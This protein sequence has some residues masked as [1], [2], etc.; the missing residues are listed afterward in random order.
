MNDRICDSCRKR[1]IDH[2]LPLDGRTRVIPIPAPNPFLSLLNAAALPSL[3]P[4]PQPMEL[5]F[6]PL[7]LLP[8]PPSSPPRAPVSSPRFD[9]ILDLFASPLLRLPL[10][11]PPSPEVAE[12]GEKLPLS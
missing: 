5:S 6:P 2:S 9:P 7:S 4:P 11:P 3:P 1:H 8:S 12:N 10:P